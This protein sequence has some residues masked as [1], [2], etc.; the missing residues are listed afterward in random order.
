MIHYSSVCAEWH[1]SMANK[2][3]NNEFSEQKRYFVQLFDRWRFLLFSLTNPTKCILAKMNSTTFQVWFCSRTIWATNQAYLQYC[4]PFFLSS[5]LHWIISWQVSQKFTSKQNSVHLITQVVNLNKFK[6][7]EDKSCPT[8]NILIQS[9]SIDPG[10]PLLLQL[11]V[12][13]LQQDILSRSSE[14]SEVLW[15]GRVYQ[16]K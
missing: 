4:L 8:V 16:Q 5:Q 2:S 12:N 6:T 13:I 15:R 9:W 3:E 7:L 11:C 1:R 14:S 10:D